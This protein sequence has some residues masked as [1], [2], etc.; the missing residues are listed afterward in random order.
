MYTSHM[1]DLERNRQVKALQRI[2]LSV[3]VFGSMVAVLG[4]IAWV[5]FS[6]MNMDVSLLL[7]QA[8][9]TLQ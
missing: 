4:V 9:T 8:P 6:N 7:P 1:D 3:L 5:G 2:L